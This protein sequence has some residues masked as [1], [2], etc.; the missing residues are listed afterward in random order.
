MKLASTSLPRA[1]AVWWKEIDRW[2]VSSV[3]R[4]SWQWPS[5]VIKPLAFALERRF[6]PVNKRAF[7]LKP[8]YFI[9]LRFTGEVESRDLHGKTDFKGTP[10]FAYPGDII[11]SKIDVR[12]GA[13]GIIPDNIPIATVTSEFPVYRIKKEVALSEYVQ[14]VFRTQHFRRIINGM[15]SGTSGR[16]R[17]QPDD[18]EKVEVPLPP[19]AE[20]K[21]IVARW[22]KV[23]DEIAAARNRVT[24]LETNIQ[25]RFLANLGLKLPDQQ[26]KLKAFAL[27]WKKLER[28]GVAFGQ[29]VST[30]FNLELGKYPVVHLRDVILDLENGWSPKCLN[31]A[32]EEGEWGV[33]KLGAVSFGYFNDKE[34]KALPSG[35]TPVHA[36]EV[37][38]G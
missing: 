5:D 37:K 34:N 29:K 1:F 21:A 31:R 11:Y 15:V 19:L 25:R 17:V 18:L 14:L 16:K 27:W 32:A 12:N 24:D 7:E 22:V 6:E 8:D 20:Q 3:R 28:W 38:Q 10:F 30:S 33:L 26:L 35:L 2:S 23:Q 36:L 13:I 4:S 9:S